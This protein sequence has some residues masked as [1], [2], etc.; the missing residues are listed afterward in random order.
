MQHTLRQSQLFSYRGMA[1]LSTPSETAI[2]RDMEEVSIA[3]PSASAESMLLGD[4]A[5][6]PTPEEAQ[7]R[8]RRR[9]ETGT[10]PPC[11]PSTSGAQEQTPLPQR[12]SRLLR[13]A[14]TKL[15]GQQ[16]GR[17]NLCSIDYSVNNTNSDYS[18]VLQNNNVSQDN[19]IVQQSKSNKG[20]LIVACNKGVNNANLDNHTSVP[21]N[22]KFQQSI[23]S[24][25]GN[26]LSVANN[27]QQLKSN[28]ASLSVAD[29]SQQ[30]KSNK[31]SLS[32]ANN[33]QQLKTNKVF[34]SVLDSSN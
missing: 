21:N 32:V 20:I 24:N 27:S 34:L 7:E 16:S 12:E 14:R 29:N 26:N 2:T 10:G 5:S 28:K 17:G 9:M 15:T 33:S 4:T 13:H 25:N 30:L 1:D 3:T 19:V 22:Q 6:D 8:K 11:T 18:S 31:A 23:V